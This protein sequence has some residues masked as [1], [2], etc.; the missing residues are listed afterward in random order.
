MKKI[1]IFIS[2]LLFYFLLFPFEVSNAYYIKQKK[3]NIEY[4][5]SHSNNILCDELY[6][7]E[8]AE[9]DLK[10]MLTLLLK[11]YNI[12]SENKVDLLYGISCIESNKGKYLKQYP[13]GPARSIYQIEKETHDLIYK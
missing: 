3:I 7:G 8:W 2:I 11:K 6:S 13:Q 1:T 4:K 5:L 10:N 9:E 12:F